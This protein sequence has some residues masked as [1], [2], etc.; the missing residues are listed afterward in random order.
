MTTLFGKPIPGSV[1]TLP[2]DPRLIVDYITH[3]PYGP[4]IKQHEVKKQEAANPLTL[5]DERHNE[6]ISA[7][8]SIS[9]SQKVQ[10]DVIQKSLPKNRDWR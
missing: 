10:Q 1:L 3:T 6:L 4:P 9:V 5:G 2:P 7:I 8:K